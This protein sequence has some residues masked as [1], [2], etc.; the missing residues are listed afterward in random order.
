MK[1]ITFLIQNSRATSPRS[2][3]IVHTTAHT[4]TRNRSSQVFI[5][6]PKFVIVNLISFGKSGFVASCVGIA[7]KNTLM[8][9]RYREDEEKH[10]S[11]F[12]TTLRKR[13]GK[14]IPLQAWTDPAASSRLR[15][16]DFKTTGT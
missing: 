16:P 1:D 12:S 8:N 7:F 6:I 13:D 15:F 10:V 11:I 9:D 14:A 2:T 4:K 5:S 3:S